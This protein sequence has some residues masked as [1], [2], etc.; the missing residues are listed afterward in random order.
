MLWCSRANTH[1]FLS[2]SSKPHS[3]APS[4]PCYLLHPKGPRLCVISCSSHPEAGVFLSLTCGERPELWVGWGSRGLRVAGL[5]DLL[6]ATTG[7]QSDGRPFPPHPKQAHPPT[8][9]PRWRRVHECKAERE[10][11]WHGVGDTPAEGNESGLEKKE[12]K[13]KS[14]NQTS[15]QENEIVQRKWVGKALR[16]ESPMACCFLSSWRTWWDWLT[17]CSLVLWD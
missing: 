17:T 3:P 10:W 12:R 6:K 14:R 4:T 5:L 1:A 15:D 16:E 13:G 11:G 8:G 9:D 7:S 2:G